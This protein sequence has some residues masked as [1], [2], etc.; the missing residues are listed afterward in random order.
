VPGYV[1]LA[2]SFDANAHGASPNG[3]SRRGTSGF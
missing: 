2:E 1:N 3:S